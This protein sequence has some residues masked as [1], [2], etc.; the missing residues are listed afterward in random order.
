MDERI[1]GFLEI[2]RD[3]AHVLL[4]GLPS[5]DK[6]TYDRLRKIEDAAMDAQDVL[7]NGAA[8]QQGEVGAAKVPDVPIDEKAKEAVMLKVP[9]QTVKAG[10]EVVG[11]E[12]MTTATEATDKAAED[13]EAQAGQ[14]A[15][16][17]TTKE[18]SIG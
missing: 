14:E 12:K 13:S 2:V 8:W 15:A 7:K 5:G 3:E 10:D 11:V 18:E 16:K 6:T 1:E 17:D 4:S 9:A